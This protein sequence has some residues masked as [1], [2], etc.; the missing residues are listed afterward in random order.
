MDQSLVR[1]G[2][3]AAKAGERERARRLLEQGAAENPADER[4]W[5]WLS[6]VVDDPGE[7]RRCLQE[8]LKVSPD[9]P[10]ALRGLAR[11]GPPPEPPADVLAEILGALRSVQR[12]LA[13]LRAVIGQGGAPPAVEEPPEL[14]AP[15]IGGNGGQR[16][17]VAVPV[18]EGVAAWLAT[19]GIT[20]RDCKQDEVT[21]LVFDQLATYLG[22]RFDTLKA[23]HD[24]IRR[25]MST[26]TPFTINL[27]SASQ[28]E[29][30]NS[31][32]FCHRLFKYAF[33][34]TYRYH[35]GTRTI[36]ATP[37]RIGRVINF[38]NGGWFERYVYL[39]TIGVLNQAQRD[40]VV[41]RNARISLANG[42]DSEL[43]LIFLVEGEPLWIEC[44]T[45][46]Y[47]NYIGR[48][49]EMRQQLEIP[50]PRAIL[51]ILGLTD[52][53]AEQLSE[54]YPISVA[55]ERSLGTCL[56]AALGLAPVEQKPEPAGEA[57]PVVAAGLAALEAPAISPAVSVVLNKAGVRPLP[58]LRPAVLRELIAL[59]RRSPEGLTLA[60]AK[61]ALAARLPVS[62]SM[63][64][65][66]LRAVVRSGS[67]LNGDG[68]LVV[69]FTMPFHRLVASDPDEL[70]RRCAASY[71]QAVLADAPD[72][73]YSA[74]NV[75]D[76]EEVTGVAAPPPAV[77]ERLR[78]ELIAG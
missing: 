48:Y 37:Q 31:T 65:D 53:L 60:Q 2:I 23:V 6:S 40:Y 16:A 27:A 4:V 55:T 29:I 54:L 73:F 70:D 62:K 72:F 71:A 68:E 46:D 8:L 10:A 11:L 1:E 58:E 66:I 64:Q 59:V 5:L 32:Q 47:Q 3:L 57:R 30:A 67:L 38:F 13:E 50:T 52:E 56:Q 76:F 14:P 61:T 22:E 21:D 19:H 35:R 49:S 45:G 15:T 43:D 34:A 28:E 20:V 18:P 7:Q 41:L 51:V 69:S 75:Q 44:K 74:A 33:L 78:A 63:L 77:L 12:E 17:P 39:K 9:H 42:D 24:R 25:H 26:G 36:Q